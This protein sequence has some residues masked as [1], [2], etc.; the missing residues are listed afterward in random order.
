MNSDRN[1]FSQDLIGTLARLY[2]MLSG[3]LALLFTGFGIARAD[4]VFL[5]GCSLFPYFDFHIMFFYF[6]P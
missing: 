6:N 3:N 5:S 1:Q 4:S 2:W